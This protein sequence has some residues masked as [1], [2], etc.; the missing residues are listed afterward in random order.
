MIDGLMDIKKRWILGQGAISKQSG[1]WICKRHGNVWM[2][3]SRCPTQEERQMKDQN[4]Q[5]YAGALPAL[6]LR[7]SAVFRS[8]AVFASS[9]FFLSRSSTSLSQPSQ[10]LS[11]CILACSSLA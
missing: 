5:A 9:N 11:R 10:P 6:R 4:S 7:W 1:M 2:L 3:R 8:R